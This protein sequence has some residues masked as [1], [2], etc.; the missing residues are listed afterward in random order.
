MGP[1]G[2]SPIPPRVMRSVCLDVFAMPEATWEAKSYNGYLMCVDRHSGWM[3]AKPI[4]KLD[5]FTGRKAAMLLLESSWGEIA[6]P[7]VITSDQG[8]EFVSQ[9]WETMCNRLGIRQA[10]SQAYHHQAYQA[11]HHQANG[12]AEVAGVCYKGFTTVKYPEGYKLDPSSSAPC[13]CETCLW[14]P[15]MSMVEF[16]PGVPS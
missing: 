13:P 3:V 7:S 10:I 2:M 15:A 12:R 9:W 16:C 11:Y 5:G 1:I 4:D 14:R 6:I 8:A